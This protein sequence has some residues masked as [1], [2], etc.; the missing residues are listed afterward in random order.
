MPSQP[1]PP[2]PHF[3]RTG[4]AAHCNRCLTGLPSSQ[5]DVDAQTLA[6]GFY[7]LG[8]LDILGLLESKTNEVERKDWKEWIWEQVRTGSYGTGFKPGSYMSPESKTLSETDQFR[9]FDPPHLIMTYVA[10]LSLAILRDDF[11]KLDRQG[12][13]KFVRSCQREDGS[14]S[15][16]PNSGDSDLREVY[17][18]FA[19]S[20]MLDDWSGVDVDRA[21]QYTRRCMSYEGGYG[22]EPSGEALG[23]TTYCA[24]ASLY[25]A[26]SSKHRDPGTSITPTE[27]SRM[28]RWLVQNQTLEHGGFSGR[29]N[30]LADACYCF[31]CGA[32]LHILGASPFVNSTTLTTFLSSCQFKFGGFAKAPNERP[33]PYHTYL[34]LAA[35]SLFPPPSEN[36]DDPNYEEWKNVSRI[37]PLLNATL[38]TEKWI[39][40]HVPAPSREFA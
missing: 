30:K 17:C 14:F 5:I 39:R 40:R 11:S 3:A 18:A 32:S 20:S 19:I 25:L 36:K 1:P 6:V 24:L 37:D 12:I 23:G 15:S 21:I 28:I 7:C 33:D 38:E 2:L 16:L 13:T 34:S 35:I 31:W 27:R 4:H 26:P 29:T 9:E 10:L 8:T 22:Q